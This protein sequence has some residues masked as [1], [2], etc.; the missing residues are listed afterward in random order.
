[1]A[2]I[3]SQSQLLHPPARQHTRLLLD[4]RAT[5]CGSSADPRPPTARPLIT[6][7]SILQERFGV[8]PSRLRVVKLLSGI[9]TA[10]HLFTCAY[11]RLKASR[12]PVRA[13]RRA[14]GHAK[15]ARV[16]TRM[17]EHLLR[18]LPNFGSWARW[19]S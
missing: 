2:D 5:T 18:K 1:M 16:N 15:G 9:F 3:E 6:G 10:F 12:T 17:C 11:W 4:A 7:G 13:R 8:T 14:G 19:S